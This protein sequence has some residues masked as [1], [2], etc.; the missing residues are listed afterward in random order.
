M[1]YLKH[2]RGKKILLINPFARFLAERANKETFENVW[3]KTGKKWFYPE[4]VEGIEFPYGL[5]KKTQEQY[6]TVFN[7]IDEIKEKISKKD[8]DVA[9]IAAGGI[10]IP[11]A[12]YIKDLGKVSI[13]LGGHLQVLF[14]VLGERWRGREDWKNRYF[15]EY[16]VNLP[17]KYIPEEK[18][19]CENSSYW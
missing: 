16:W 11:L 17:E 10:A 15:N 6:D 2:L 8:F 12:S 13:S 7:L 19:E 9:F 4:S 18:E 5:S 3:K 1:C 14:G